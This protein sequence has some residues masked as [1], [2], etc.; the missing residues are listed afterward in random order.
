M[1]YVDDLK[2][3]IYARVSSDKQA[4]AG[5]IGSQIAAI[6]ERLKA[7]GVSVE[8]ELRFI[9]DGYSGTTLVRPALERLRDVAAQG[10]IDRL[11]V[12]APDRLS[13]N[14]AYQVV[15]V[16]ELQG[17]GVEVCFL[18]QGLGETPETRLLVQVQ[19]MFAEFMRAKILETM[20]RGKLYR[21]RMGSAVAIANA[22]YGYKYV[23]PACP[24]GLGSYVISLQDAAVVKRI[25]EGVGKKRWSIG[26]VCRSLDSD[27][28]ASPKGNAH[29]DRKT[30]W[31]MLRNPA[32]KGTAAFGKTRN[33]PRRAP[34]VRPVPKYAVP[35]VTYSAY[36]QPEDEWVTIAVPAIVGDDLFSA[37]KEQLAE[38]RRRA[39]ERKAG[40]RTLLRGL[41]VCGK[42]GYSVCA[43][44]GP[45][46][47]YYRCNG[48]D[49]RRFG[50]QRMCNSSSIPAEWLE[51]AVWADAQAL[52]KEPERIQRE[53][54]RRLQGEVSGAVNDEVAEIERSM[55]KLKRKLNR[56]LDAFAEGLIE[57]ADLGP[58][59]EKT[60]AELA[61]MA[62]ALKEKKLERDAAAELRLVVTR[63]E[64]FAQRIRDGLQAATSE[65]KREIL[66]LL[67]KEVEVDE[68]KIR[69]VYRV[70]PGPGGP[71]PRTESFRHCGRR[72]TA[73]LQ[74]EG[75]R[76]RSPPRTGGRHC[77]PQKGA[78]R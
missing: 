69:V 31:G 44:G 47:R 66:R 56:L 49:P 65:Q 74:G 15:V 32:Y 2:V 63:V 17:N 1:S 58:R 22:P 60:Q 50:G 38:N 11:Y 3:A 34:L 4:N 18:N 59:A 26:A 16:E 40:A 25:F 37:V 72:Q 33:G 51:E 9:D 10:R 76:D 61:S 14:Y 45:A 6:E 57:K 41:V 36:R 28:I 35:K 78:P 68:T 12:F 73:A 7:D 39:R 75:A 24:G 8:Q 52:L 77:G 46:H 30:V 27:G 42:C 54:E 70:N 21:A 20:R 43:L 5:T 53:F 48:N 71:S 67:I 29:W 13:R 19:G 55:V 62:A 23:P 64:D